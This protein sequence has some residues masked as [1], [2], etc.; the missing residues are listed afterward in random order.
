MALV[1]RK[2]G[3]VSV[4]LN[5]VMQRANVK[6]MLKFMNTEMCFAISHNVIHSC[7]IGID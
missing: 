6:G 1:S 2:E 4:L 5:G 7:S 3:A